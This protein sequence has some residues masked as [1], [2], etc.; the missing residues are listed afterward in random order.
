MPEPKVPTPNPNPTA[1]PTPPHTPP[2]PVV[3]THPPTTPIPPATTTKFPEVKHP[4]EKESESKLADKM[5]PKDNEADKA[6]LL[7]QINDIL[8]Q[9]G[10]QESNVGQ[11]SE[12]WDLLKRYRTLNQTP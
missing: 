6:E 2:P 8:V 12:Y 10:G 4:K 11:N 7:S 5:A 1:I 3:P 9:H